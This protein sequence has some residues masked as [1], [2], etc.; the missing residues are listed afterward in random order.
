M[1]PQ[2]TT[3]V[4]ETAAWQIPP[5]FEVMRQIGNVPEDDYRRTF[6]LGVG[7]ILAVGAKSAARAENILRKLR[8]PHFRIGSIVRRKRG[9]PAVEYR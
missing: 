5:V 7:M 3:A 9:A 8:E 1:L 6:N 2:G 4:I